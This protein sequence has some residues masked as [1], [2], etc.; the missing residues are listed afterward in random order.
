MT[1]RARISSQ[2]GF[3]LLELLISTAIML[4]VTAGIFTLVNPSQGMA[5]SQ[6]EAAD[7]QQRMRIA[8]DTLF[9]E[10]LI[11]GAGPYQGAD[12]D[13]GSLNNFFAPIMPRR[14]AVTGGDARD[15]FRPDAI[16][17]TYLPNSYSQTT[18]DQAMPPNS[19][20]LKVTYPPNCPDRELCGFTAGMVVIIFDRAGHSDTFK[21]THVQ[22]KAGHLQHRGSD[23]SYAY[24]SGALITQ[25]VTNTFYLDSA[26][27][28]LKKHDGS[29]LDVPIVDN[30]V[31]LVFEYFGDPN[32]P[33]LPK[34]PAGTANCLYDALGNFVNL[35]VLAADE[36]SL[37]RLTPTML[38]NG[39]WCGGGNSQYDADL[40]RVKKVRVTLRLQAAAAAVRGTSTA[41]FTNPGTATDSIKMVPDYTVQF[42]VSPRNLNLTR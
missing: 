25:V 39:P 3:S 11:A 17:L 14:A 31:G 22:D 19:S 7:L 5:Q 26:T 4:T 2:A 41:L 40:L 20:E 10:L 21:I 15:V 12:E 35:P 1:N 8:S 27:R 34:P 16:T 13:R 23:L 36:G 37:A 24:A 38:T 42:D 6:P 32:P 29:D 18:I 33:K 28:Q 9:K 30:V